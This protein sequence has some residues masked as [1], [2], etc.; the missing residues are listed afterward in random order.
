MAKLM[1]AAAE[2]GHLVLAMGDFNM[3]PSSLAYRLLTARAPMVRDAWRVV[4][5]DSAL[6]PADDD[7]D[8]QRPVPSAD[9]NL[10]ENGAASD[11]P[12]CTWRWPSAQQRRL[13]SGQPVAAVDPETPDR[14][15][16][17]LDYVFVGAGAD[18]AGGGWVVR[19]VAVGMTMPHPKWKV[20]LSDHFAVEATLVFDPSP[21]LEDAP[22]DTAIDHDAMLAD[23][24]AEVRR[25]RAREESQLRWRSRHFF[26]CVAVAMGCFV[27][28]CFSPHNGVAFA[29]SI[30]SSLGL[31][32]GTIDGLLS[33]LFFRS[34]LRA[35]REFEWEVQNARA[36]AA[37]VQELQ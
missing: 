1:C 22:S 10:R 13:L 34:E 26:A 36:A 4:H 6:G 33:L 5:P 2:R 23:V 7:P 19:R 24:L 30:V 17:R 14:H 27:A 8:L 35:L 32:G 31:T 25:Y 3:V 16:K 29:L 12:F 18:A 15:G 37:S 28:V 21:T 11:G 20:S 9:F